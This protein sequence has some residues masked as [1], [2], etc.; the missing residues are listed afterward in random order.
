MDAL[1]KS[2]IWIRRLA[3]E[4]I[5]RDPKFERFMSLVRSHDENVKARKW[6]SAH[7]DI[8][9]A[10]SQFVEL[11]NQIMVGVK[12][13]LDAR[14]KKQKPVHDLLEGYRKHLGQISK[15]AQVISENADG[16]LDAIERSS[17]Q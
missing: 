5:D 15:A 17:K 2:E 6:L 9:A 8:E 4:D 16:M 13:K 7:D 12:E 1:K 11:T 10:F 3:D 14:E